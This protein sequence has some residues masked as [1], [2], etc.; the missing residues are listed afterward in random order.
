MESAES[1]A[2]RRQMASRINRRRAEQ[3]A[4]WGAQLIRA[5][6]EEEAAVHHGVP[7]LA[8][9]HRADAAAIR[10]EI[11]KFDAEATSPPNLV[12]PDAITEE[13]PMSTE[14]AAADKQSLWKRALAR[15]DKPLPDAKPASGGF[16]P[17][18]KAA[19]WK[20]ALNRET[21]E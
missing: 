8:V 10:A 12:K 16:S 13:K 21:Q 20:R 14:L 6:R 3:R 17:E 2:F 5:E 9:R 18:Q 11:A 15:Q 1:D 19:M 7:A 4:S